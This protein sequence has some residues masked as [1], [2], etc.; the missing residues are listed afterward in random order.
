MF[1]PLSQRTATPKHP[2]AIFTGIA[3]FK[4][5]LGLLVHSVPKWPVRV[6]YPFTCSLTIT[7][8]SPNMRAL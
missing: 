7:Q 1:R 2:G 4:R 8:R 5:D 6:E 3:N